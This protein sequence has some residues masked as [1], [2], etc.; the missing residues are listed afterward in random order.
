ML[1][2]RR[3]ALLQYATRAFGSEAAAERW[4]DSAN[5]ALGGKAPNDM[6]DTRE[7][8]RKVLDELELLA[9]D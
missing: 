4:L 1:R 2:L 6:A 3:T 7:G 9:A 5:P 8:F